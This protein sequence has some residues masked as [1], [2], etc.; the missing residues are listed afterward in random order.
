M[1]NKTINLTTMDFTNRS[2]SS[3]DQSLQN[4]RSANYKPNIWDYNRLQSLK[5]D[6]LEEKYER[7]AQKLKEEVVK[8]IFVENLDAL[9]KLELIDSI[10]KLGLANLFEEEI[11]EALNKVAVIKSHHSIKE[12]LY[13]TALCF[14]LLRQHGYKVSQGMFLGFMN[15]K[16]ELKKSMYL[17]VNG[18]IELFEASH[19]ALEGEN[20]LDDAKSFTTSSLQSLRLSVNDDKLIKRMDQAL[21][22]PLHW[23]VEWYNVKR[24]INLREKED[25][26][27]PILLELAKLNFNMVQATHQ[28]DLRE[29]S[30]DGRIF[31]KHYLWKQGGTT[32]VIH[33]PLKSILR[34]GGFLPPAELERGDSP[35]CIVCF[36][37]ENNVT[38]EVAQ[39]HIGRLV[40][41]AWKKMNKLGINQSL[42]LREFVK[43][44]INIARVAQFIYHKRDGFGVQD[45]GTKD[46]VVA[47]LVEPLA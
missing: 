20:I 27:H 39:E 7:Q 9:A 25:K 35:S 23:R 4:R 43:C 16:G 38:E 45:P 28:R 22:V 31:A 2:S 34:M 24:H 29:I 8:C 11:K 36:M 32:R 12:D 44:T 40:V 17:N 26:T 46:H 19:L 30:R 37:Q 33:H 47:L 5:S 41:S 14:R 10:Q 15:D 3:A 6:Y 1:Q 13:A 18:M 21:E 42:V